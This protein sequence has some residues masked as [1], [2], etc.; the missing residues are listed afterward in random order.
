MFL[1]QNM[2]QA[3][4]IWPGLKDSATTWSQPRAEPPRAKSVLLLHG[5]R[6]LTLDLAHCPGL[7]GL[8]PPLTP[9]ELLKGEKAAC[10]TTP[11][12][13]LPAQC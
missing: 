9:R 8:P 6:L 3:A 7:S 10:R 13:R 2:Q 12:S 5:V 4:G 1:L 11:L